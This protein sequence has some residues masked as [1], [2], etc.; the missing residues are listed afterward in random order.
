MPVCDPNIYVEINDPTP[1]AI[2]SIAG[3]P[4]NQVSSDI[5]ICNENGS[6]ISE[7]MLPFGFGS[8]SFSPLKISSNGASANAGFREFSKAFFLSDHICIAE[9]LGSYPKNQYIN[10]SSIILDIDAAQIFSV[11]LSRSDR[12][13]TFM[14]KSS[15]HK[16]SSDGERDCVGYVRETAFGDLYVFTDGTSD[17][18]LTSLPIGRDLVIDEIPN[19]GKFIFENHPVNGKPKTQ[20]I[21]KILLQIEYSGQSEGTLDLF[22]EEFFDFISLGGGNDVVDSFVFSKPQGFS[23]EYIIIP[24][25]AFT[26]QPESFNLFQITINNPTMYMVDSSYDASCIPNFNLTI[27]NRFCREIIIEKIS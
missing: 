26:V 24:E 20:S 6:G 14:F 12:Q 9:E 15:Y 23:S 5:A 1:P 4:V 16:K 7:N 17:D 18:A 27:H 21:R 13:Y 22:F 10:N 8:G 11:K 3:T 25:N 19:Y 2:R